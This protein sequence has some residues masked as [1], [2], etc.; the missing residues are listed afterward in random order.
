[1]AL[2]VRHDVLAAQLNRDS[3]PLIVPFWSFT[4]GANVA[5][6]CFGRPNRSQRLGVAA[7]ALI[8]AGGLAV[9]LSA[10]RTMGLWRSRIDGNVDPFMLLAPW[11]WGIFWVYSAAQLLVVLMVG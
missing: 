7:G 4:A 9:R 11:T 8:W 3:F 10:E 6:L 5:A 1:M 2:Q